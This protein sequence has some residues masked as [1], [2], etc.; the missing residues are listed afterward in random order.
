MNRD[1]LETLKAISLEECDILDGRTQ[2]NKEIYMDSTSNVIDS[3]RLLERGKLIQV[4]PHTR[5][6]H[7]PMH[8]H[9][10][11]EVIYM[12]R[13]QTQHIINGNKVAL[14]EGELLFLNQSAT[15]EVL[16]AG[17]DDLAV[18]LII[19]PEFFDFTLQMMREEENQLRDF[20][21]GCLKSEDD[22]INY[23][24]F[25]VAGVLPIQNLVENLIWTIM[26]NQQN[27]RSINQITM[28]LL[29]LHLLNHTDKVSVG[30]NQYDKE[31]MIRLFRHIEEEYKTCL[32]SD[33]ANELKCDLYWLSRKVKKLTGKTYTELVQIKRLNQAA[34]LLTTTRLTV[35]DI[36]YAIGYDNLSYF[37]RIFRAKFRM[38]PKE[39]RRCK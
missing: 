2:I 15:Q 19:L 17:V 21:V 3:K 22:K 34:Y 13:G 16:P 33:L 39:Y 30:E 31:L 1:I 37:H 20:I 27:N 36:G 8:K 23:L 38:S 9:N 28:G 26:N 32:L 24:H 12:Y 14:Q 7:F 11:V 5:F 6:V 25:K 35:A 29:F 18:N 4:R 10:Y